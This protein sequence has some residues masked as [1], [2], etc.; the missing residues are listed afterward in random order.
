MVHGM[1]TARLRRVRVGSLEVRRPPTSSSSSPP[2]SPTP[3]R[4][5]ASLTLALRRAS[6]PLAAAE[7]ARL[8][9]GGGR[10]RSFAAASFAA[11][12]RDP[13]L[14]QLFPCAAAT[15]APPSTSPARRPAP[16]P[17]RIA[18]YPS[19]HRLALAASAPS[20]TSPSRLRPALV[21]TLRSLQSTSCSLFPV[22]SPRARADAESAFLPLPPPLPPCSA[23]PPPRRLGSLFNMPLDI[24]ISVAVK[25]FRLPPP[26]RRFLVT[27]LG[28]WSPLARPCPARAGSLPGPR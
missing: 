24:E 6:E 19:P 9:A 4:P 8:R 5:R 28:C 2:S 25:R 1:A 27:S 12:E 18:V 7:S 15:T 11:L 26:T 10:A 21:P 22:H 16:S 17:H 20:A 14:T 3:P 13:E 23:R